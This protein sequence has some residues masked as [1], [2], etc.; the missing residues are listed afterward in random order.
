M[1]SLSLDSWQIQIIPENIPVDSSL[2]PS[3]PDYSRAKDRGPSAREENRGSFSRWFKFIP[4]RYG[5]FPKLF[6]VIQVYSQQIQIIPDNI[7]VFTHIHV[8]SSWK[9]DPSK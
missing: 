2:F 9:R 6:P 4:G 7:P 1:R 5:L 3:D 8:Y